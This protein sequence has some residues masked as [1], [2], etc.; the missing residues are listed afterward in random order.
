MAATARVEF[1]LRPEAKERIDR[2]AELVNVPV[3]E[4]LRAAAE[5]RAEEILRA[6]R[7]TVVSATFFDEMLA[8]LTAPPVPN[9]PT[10]RAARRARDLFTD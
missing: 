4:F 7:E 3:S 9:E 10:R 8:A 1:R 2:A 6:E 5:E